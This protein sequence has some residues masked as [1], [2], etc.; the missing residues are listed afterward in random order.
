VWKWA[1]AGL[2]AERIEQLKGE[3][4]WKNGGVGRRCAGC[5]VRSV[6]MLVA[7]EETRSQGFER[8]EVGRRLRDRA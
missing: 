8:F 3:G 2:A 5:M 7:G 1:G 6:G 4:D